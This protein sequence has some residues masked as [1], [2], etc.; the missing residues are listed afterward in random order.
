MRK[1]ILLFLLLTVACSDDGDGAPYR[2][3]PNFVDRSAAVQCEPADLGDVAVEQLRSVTDTSVL[4]L[5][6]AQ[7]RVTEYDD[8]LRPLWTL[9]YPRR[10]PAAVDRPVS[11]TLLGDSAVAIVARGGL[12]LVI[13]GRRGRLIHA[14]PLKFVPVS[15]AAAGDELLITAMPLGA[16]PG[17]LLFRF[18]DGVLRE[19][20]VP[21]RTYADMTVG[22]LGNSTLVETFPGATALVVHQLFAPRA[23]RV[24]HDESVVPLPMP[25]PDATAELADVVP[26]AP[27]TEATLDDL[28]VPA[29]AMSVDRGRREVYILTRSGRRVDDRRERAILRTDDQL[30]YLGSY[31][32]DAHA[33]HMA[34]LPRRRAALVVDHL[35][36]SFLCPLDADTHSE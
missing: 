13:L 19:V 27:I 24:T 35:D 20:P 4:V 26:Q 22:A 25:T 15:M 34:V 6:A 28:L 9:A 10:G 14:E 36:R 5:D 17:S 30:G 32:L 29:M 7:G 23:F 21:R 31:L 3:V 33:V 8:R 18:R 16:S 1:S 2:V 12:R 11:A